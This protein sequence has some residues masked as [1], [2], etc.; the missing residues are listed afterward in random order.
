M[1]TKPTSR[2]A[3]VLRGGAVLGA[4]VAAAGAG[5]AGMAAP[6]LLAAGSEAA[7]AP[8]TQLQ[9]LQQQLDHLGDLEAI[10][11]VHRTFQRAMETRDAE[12][13]AALFHECARLD[14]GG[15]VAAGKA[16]I[17]RLLGEL[18]RGESSWIV[19]DRYRQGV[20]RPE[21]TLMVGESQLDARATFHTEA[22]VCVPL[23][24][25]STAA[26]MARLQGHV[27]H[28]YWE[29]GRFDA[30]YVKRDGRWEILSL[31]Y[32]AG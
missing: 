12:S 29:A 16:A 32:S 1:T 26:H 19:H 27:A 4:G 6:G 13:A 7:P 24:V 22:E 28:R 20:L 14:L 18:Q 30:H 3:F 11:Q 2:R 23:R 9:R 21:D 8:S 5:T 31:T 15:A 10:R 17:W 25:D